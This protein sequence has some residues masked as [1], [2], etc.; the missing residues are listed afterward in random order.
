MLTASTVEDASLAPDPSTFLGHP[1]GL[2]VLFVTEMWERFSFYGMRALLILYMTQK[3]LLD[4]PGG[5]AGLGGLQY[6][7]LRI[8][9]PVSAAGLASQVYGLYSGLVYLI[10]TAL[11]ADRCVVTGAD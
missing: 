7:L 4:D 8:T 9:G 3:L 6:L 1:A 5:I 10:P 11:E 2:V